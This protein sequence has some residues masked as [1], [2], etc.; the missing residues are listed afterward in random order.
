MERADSEGRLGTVATVLGR[1]FDL[2]PT[3][4]IGPAVGGVFLR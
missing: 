1:V 2:V 4:V 3:F